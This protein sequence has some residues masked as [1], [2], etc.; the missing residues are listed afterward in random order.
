MHEN[1]SVEHTVQSVEDLLQ[2]NLTLLASTTLQNGIQANP[3]SQAL[4]L[5]EAEIASKSRDF[6]AAAPQYDVLLKDDPD[7]PSLLIKTAIAW[8][9]LGEIDKAI[10]YS[11]R[12][13]EKSQHSLHSVLT[14]ADLYERFNRTSEAEL[15]LNEMQEKPLLN[16]NY[17]RLIARILIAKKEYSEAVDFIYS[18]FNLELDDVKKSKLYFLLSKAYDRLGEYDKAWDAASNAHDLDDT[19]FDENEFFAQF[20]EMYSFMTKEVLDVLVE[21]PHTEFEPLFIVGNPRSGT[22]LLEQILSMHSD[23]QNGGEMSSG[24][25]MQAEVA[26]LTDSYHAW[27]M[28]LIDLNESDA[29]QLSQRYSSACEFFR[30]G[31]KIV[32]NKALNLHTQLGFL[33]KILPSS[34]AIVLQR[35]PLD[36]A[37]SCFTT[38]L[39][40]AGLP[41]TSSLESIGKTWLK[42]KQLSELW[43]ELLS[44]PVMELHYESLVSNQR[45]ETEKILQFLGVPWQEECMEFYKSEQ[46]A[47]TISFDQVNQKMYS[48][49]SG[50]WKNY[51]THLNPIIE[52]CS[53]YL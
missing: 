26:S 47:R 19:P 43:L 30:K 2:K 48:S 17:H 13:V 5:L 18:L 31:S 41:Y 45:A 27:P 52:L 50:R 32:S 49:S 34:K 4:R 12:A 51:E 21:G 3:T 25:L 7:N 40:A 1:R 8:S 14:L 38:N 11:K 10:R 39:L 15:I 23:I 24:T 28:N 46:V 44:I 6:Y 37:V 9:R 20:D 36:N 16:G 22:S 29:S 42:R 35:H 33:S 53:D